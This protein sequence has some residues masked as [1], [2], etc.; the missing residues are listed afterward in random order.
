MNDYRSFYT[1]RVNKKKE[2]YI[3]Q[4]FINEYKFTEICQKYE[5]SGIFADYLRSLINYKV[6]IIADDS[7][8]M[9]TFTNYGE[10]RWNELC[11]FISTVFSVTEMIENSPL[12]VYFLNRPSIIN[13]QQ[14]NQIAEAFNFP[15][16]G[17]TPIVPVLRHVLS[18]QYDPSYV[19]RIIIICTDGEPTDE[20]NNR[21]IKQL[22]NVLMCQRKRNDFVSFLACTDDDDSIAYLNRWDVEIPRVD[23]I[24]DDYPNEKKEVQRA[25]GRNFSFTFGEYVVKT[26]LGSVI[27]SLDK[28]DEYGIDVDCKFCSMM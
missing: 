18:E 4:R 25:Q 10:P 24:D 17:A 14:L 13:V 8:S 2:S 21:N 16:K 7:G 26:L 27:P 5:I 11:R 15:P 22:Y 12:D 1:F 3:Q 9:N 23:V 20:N 6:V 19:G 28:L